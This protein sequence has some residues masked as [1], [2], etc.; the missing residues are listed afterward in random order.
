[1]NTTRCT[2]LGLCCTIALLAPA[3]HAAAQATEDAGSHPDIT[4]FLQAASRDNKVAKQALGQLA[5]EWDDAYTAIFLDLAR[6]LRPRGVG[7]AG[8]GSE[9]QVGQAA[10]DNPLRGFAGAG[11]PAGPDVRGRLVSFLQRQT[12]KKFGQDLDRW[13]RWVW[14]EPYA[15]HPAYD[16][17]KA[18]IYSRVDPRMANFFPP[19]VPTRVRLDQVDWGGVAVD[20]IPGLDHPQAVPAAEAGWLKDKHVVF[21]VEIDGEARAYPKRIL[22]WH[23]LARDSLGGR[24]ITVVYCTLCGTVIPYDN[25][26]AGKELTLGTSGLLYRSNKLLYD[27]NSNSLWSALAGTPLIGPLARF[28]L[29]LRRFPVVTTTW[30]EW[31]AAHP[32]TTVLSLDTGH[33]RDYTEGAAYR[34]YYSN[35]RLMFEVPEHDGRLKN[36]AEVLTFVVSS[37]EG[38]SAQTTPVAIAVSFLERNPVHGMGVGSRRLVI[39]TSPGGA[40]RVY[41][42]GEQTFVRRLDDGTLEDDQGRTWRVTEQA[43]VTD[44]DAAPRARVPAQRAF[45]FGWYNQYPE[46][47]LV[48]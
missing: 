46:T 43:L 1:M 33:E 44:A 2:L 25:E 10:G 39:V 15:P 23:E 4:L 12:G 28:D 30:G 47:L 45:W 42:A 7:P 17:F 29:K 20:G 13:R 34:D 35:D 5:E 27:A 36:K 40:N 37:G 9:F 26:V 14:E 32:D 11:G 22:A 38:E 21:G 24:E 19:G 3:P 18:T 6:M 31:K 48:K 16:T 41:D 8:G